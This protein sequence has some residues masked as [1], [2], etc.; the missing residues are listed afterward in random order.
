M[1]RL[2]A[3]DSATAKGEAKDLL[4]AVQAKYGAVPNSFKVMANSPKT[5]AAFPV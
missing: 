5:L 2:R 3:I 1:Q 4:D